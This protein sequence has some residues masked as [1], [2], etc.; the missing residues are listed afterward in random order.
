MQDLDIYILKM[1]LVLS[2]AKGMNTLIDEYKK[3]PLTE[4]KFLFPRVFLMI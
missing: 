4:V 1:V 3:P 2:R